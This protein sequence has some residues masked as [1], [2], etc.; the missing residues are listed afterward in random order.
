MRPWL[1]F[2]V[3]SHG[4]AKKVFAESQGCRLLSTVHDEKENVSF[5]DP[6]LVIDS[7]FT[8]SWN[9]QCLKPY[10]SI[11]FYSY[12]SVMTAFLPHSPAVSNCAFYFYMCFCLVPWLN[13]FFDVRFA[14]CQVETQR[15]WRSED[16]EAMTSSVVVHPYR[17]CSVYLDTCD[18]NYDLFAKRRKG[19]RLLLPQ[20]NATLLLPP[21]CSK[22]KTSIG[23]R[24]WNREI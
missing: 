13:T 9:I 5:P 21:K 6:Q 1:R 7:S 4:L 24:A 3:E 11:P 17:R 23:Q 22:R 16:I 2:L 20:W 18:D 15:L 19:A 12:V 8:S 14:A 10:N